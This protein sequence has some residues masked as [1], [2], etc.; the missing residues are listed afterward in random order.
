MRDTIYFASDHAGFELKNKLIGYVRDELDYEVV[1]CGAYTFDA[2]DDFTDFIAKAAREVSVHPHSSKA[3]ILGSSGQGEAMMA[4]RFHDVRAAVYYGGDE[5][6]IRLSRKHNDANVLSLGARFLAVKEAQKAVA[7][8][9]ATPH[10]PV[11]KYDRRIEELE[12]LSEVLPANTSV[13]LAPSLP[14][15]SFEELEALFTKLTGTAKEMQVDIVDGVFAPSSPH[16]V[17]NRPR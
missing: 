2:E 17:R 16:L 11:T 1:D 4:N 3:I 5:D 12:S 8:W 7:L 6:I 14:A 15:S 13:S 10:N 9:L